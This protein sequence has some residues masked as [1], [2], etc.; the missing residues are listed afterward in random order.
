MTNKFDIAIFIGRFQPFHN[1]HLAVVKKALAQAQYILI[2]CGSSNTP[3][4]LKNP[5]T[6]TEREN[7]ILNAFSPEEQKRIY[8]A[9]IDDYPMMMP[10]GSLT[11]NKLST[12]P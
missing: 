1:G 11:S 9:T 4:N 5:F 3:R 2:L 10:L 6:F 8:C 7:I 12:R